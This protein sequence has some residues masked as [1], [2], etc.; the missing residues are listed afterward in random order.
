MPERPLLL[1]P[2]PETASRSKLGEGGGS[3]SP[4]TPQRQWD[5]LSPIFSQLQTTFNTRRVEIQQTNAGI[6][7]EQVLVI[8]TIGSIKNFANA[9]KRIVGLEWMGEIEIDEILPDE[10]FYDEKHPEKNLNGRLF[11]IMTNQRALEEMLSLWQ[12]YQSEPAMQFERG[13]TKFRDVFSYLKSIHRWDVQ[14][15]LLE[16]GLID[17]WQE[18]LDTDGNR[19]IQFE[20][21]LW[22]RKSA[23]LQV[24]SASYVSQ[25]VEE[26]GGRILSQ[27]V[28]DGIAYHGLLA[29]LP[30]SAVR[31]IIDDPS[32]ELVKCENVMFF[33]PT[34]QMV[35]GDTSPEGDIEIATI[36]ETPLPTGE[37]VVAVLDGVPL[38]NHRL[39][40]GRITVDD[41]DNWEADYAVG[42]RV[43]GTSM[44][45]L[46]VHGDL[47]HPTTPLSR[48]VYIRPIMKPHDWYETPRPESIPVDCLAVDLIQGAVKRIFEGED[49]EEP[50]APQVK[51]INLSVGDRSLQFTH[52]MSP[53]AK[54]LDLLSVKYGVLFIV[55]AGNHPTPISLEISRNGFQTIRADDLEAATITALY[56]DARNRRLLSPAETINGLTIGAIHQDNSQVINHANRLDPY[57][58]LLPSPLSAFGSGYGRAIKPEL[59][60]SGGK[61]WY[62]LPPLQTDPATIEPAI[63][64]SP[65]GIKSASPGS[66]AGELDATSYS[67]GT[68]NATALISRAAG[69]C[70][71]TLQNIQSEQITHQ[72]PHAC[73]VPLIKAMLVHGCS[74]N[75]IGDNLKS[76]IESSDIGIEI[77]ERAELLYTRSADISKE[78][79]R[80]YKALLARWIGYGVAQLDRAFECTAQRATLLGFG[81]LSDKEAHVFRLP[82]PP[83]LSSLPEQRR[84]TVTL[85]WLSPISVNTQR[86][87]KAS[88]WF[89]AK[90][91]LTPSRSDADWQTVKRGTVQHEVFEGHTAEP[92]IDGDVIEIKVNCRKDAGKL[93]NPVAYGLAVSLEVA[94]GVDIAVYN[95][96]RSKIA[97]TIQ[98]QPATEQGA[99]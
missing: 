10:D 76:Q 67:C 77:A 35:V 30:A 85:G 2:T 71:E 33:R 94:E 8:E 7:P 81:E 84:L 75:Q 58:Q 93:E 83:S 36:E 23:A 41:P 89:E 14:D 39:L 21:E 88:L 13:L 3:V 87:R 47:N 74:W 24:A 96:I 69:I 44:V 79:G 55:S 56:R 32:T 50:V 53:I 16:T 15:R 25:L 52:S 1:F 92:F 45:S 27:S 86:Y 22:F 26:A 43:H 38:A 65:P 62:R 19:V 91:G 66:L 54:L 17:I 98:I 48:P 68:S 6:E 64:N 29:E 18:D 57:V 60:F 61:Q 34:G 5:R 72:I 90:H 42:E 9:V 99:D 51:I 11:F 37:P 40:A 73:E 20:A 80:R 97:P 4:P 82:L 70:Y 63:F 46:I 78:I 95:E 31:S 12:R 28:I 49:G 59:V